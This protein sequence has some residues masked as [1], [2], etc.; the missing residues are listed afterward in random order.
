MSKF[1]KTQFNFFGG[2][3]TYNN[4]FIARFKHGGMG[5]FKR[6]LVK[7]F[8]VEEYLQLLEEMPPVKVLETKGYIHPALRRIAKK[9][10]FNFESTVEV[11]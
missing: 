1:D 10:S 3:L 11:A 9:N 6:F 7:N 8:S 4:T 5:D 2:Y